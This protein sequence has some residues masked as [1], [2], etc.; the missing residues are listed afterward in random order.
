M[1]HIQSF[2][3][4]HSAGLINSRASAIKWINLLNGV[5]PYDLPKLIDQINA[6]EDHLSPDEETVLNQLICSGNEDLAIQLVE[7]GYKQLDRLTVK[8]DCWPE[9]KAPIHMAVERGCLPLLTALHE[10]GVSLESELKEGFTPMSFFFKEFPKDNPCFVYL[11]NNLPHE[12]F[13]KGV[14]I[15][16][17]I[18]LSLVEALC[19]H[20]IATA[21]LCIVQLRGGIGTDH[22]LLHYLIVDPDVGPERIQ[23]A[24]DLGA[25]VNFLASMG[26][27]KMGRTTSPLHR[28]VL[29][30][31]EDKELIAELLI[32][33]GANMNLTS[34][35]DHEMFERLFPGGN[36]SALEEAAIHAPALAKRMM[37]LG[38]SVEIAPKVHQ[39]LLGM[40]DF[41]NGVYQDPAYALMEVQDNTIPTPLVKS[42]RFEAGIDRKKIEEAVRQIEGCED[43]LT[44]KLLQLVAKLGDV[45]IFICRKLNEETRPFEKG[46]KGFFHTFE[47]DK[48]VALDD[49]DP[50][51]IAQ[52][53]IHELGHLVDHRIR[54]EQ[55]IGEA[56]SQ[57]YGVYLKNEDEPIGGLAD[58]MLDLSIQN[59]FRAIRED[60]R[61]GEAVSEIIAR[62]FQSSFMIHQKSP[63]SVCRMRIKGFETILEGE[64]TTKNEVFE[65]FLIAS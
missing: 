54:L 15:C 43:P 7:S 65:K 53:I 3:N 12:S 45:S 31:R 44:R 1:N 16:S 40:G 62:T 63:A 34:Q 10:K 57:A 50:F 21:A 5:A 41:Q 9:K 35:R 36:R 51:V 42:C 30:E 55:K 25:D 11:L 27:T 59:L 39:G 22:Q 37:E 47:N 2:G 23:K 61:D 33:N 18:K 8:R 20:G 19:K 58:M 64:V 38:G 60:Y 13:W 17:D 49:E 29:S 26:I 28:L 56:L 4:F 46:L 32:K 48:I 24:I 52:V 14:Q 6:A